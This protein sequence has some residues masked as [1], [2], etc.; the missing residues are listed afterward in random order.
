MKFLCRSSKYPETQ[1]MT[2]KESTHKWKLIQYSKKK[3]QQ[4][5]I[6]LFC[7]PCQWNEADE[8]KNELRIIFQLFEKKMKDCVLIS[9]YHAKSANYLQNPIW[10]F[11]W[12]RSL[13]PLQKVSSTHCYANVYFFFLFHFL[14]AV[15]FS[16]NL[17]LVYSLYSGGF[18]VFISW[19]QRTHTH[20]NA[21]RKASL[22]VP[23]S[24]ACLYRLKSLN[25]VYFLIIIIKQLESQKINQ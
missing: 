22:V 14:R 10:L 21:K 25:Y 11:F 2:L 13:K 5:L 7:L 20:T 15:F 12:L 4:A 1:R 9:N 16:F 3:T 24:I 18:A 17:S 6:P 19:F 23:L 8:G